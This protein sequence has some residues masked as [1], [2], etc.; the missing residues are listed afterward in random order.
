VRPGGATRGKWRILNGKNESDLISDLEL[1][2]GSP[3]L[4]RLRTVLVVPCYNKHWVVYWRIQNLWGLANLVALTVT[5][6]DDTPLHFMDDIGIVFGPPTDYLKRF[7]REK[8]HQGMVSPGRLF[9]SQYER[10]HSWCMCGSRLS[11][12]QVISLTRWLL[13]R[14]FVT[15]SDMGEAC[16]LCTNVEVL[17]HYVHMRV[18]VMLKYDYLVVENWW[19]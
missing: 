18:L 9:D 19:Y 6:L 1:Q 12:C 13:I 2:G 11:Y 7:S 8:R 4:C 15:P 3:R 10:G 14:I 5:E 17:Y 16:S